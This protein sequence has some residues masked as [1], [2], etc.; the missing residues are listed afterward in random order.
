MTISADAKQLLERDR[1][2]VAGIE[3]LRFFPIAVQ[4]GKGSW[5]TE[6]GGRKLLDLSSTWTACGLGHG[7]P[8]L[9][10]AM[11]KAAQ[12]PAGAGGLSAAHPDSVG[13]AE[14]LLAFVP[15][16]GD[17][18][19]YFGHAGTDANEVVFRSARRATGRKRIVT[20]KHGYHGG[21]GVA[22]KVSDVHIAAGVEADPDLFL[23]TYPNPFRPHVTGPD[24][25]RASLEATIAEIDTELAKGDVCCLMAEPILSDGGLIVPPRGF[26]SRLLEVCRKH[27]VLLA[28]DE[29]KMGL[30]RP[31]VMHAFQLD[32]IVPDIVTFGKLIGGGLP[33]S[34]AVA[35]AWL[36]DGPPASALLTTAGNPICTAVGRQVMRTLKEEDIPARAKRAGDRFLA[37]LRALMADSDVIGDVRGE[38]LAIGLELVKSRDT[39]ARDRLLTTKVVYRAFEL[40]AV[41]HYVGGNVLEIT[42]PLVIEDSEIDLAVDIL[43]QSIKDA[44]AGKVS[45][46]TVA[47]FA[48]W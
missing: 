3:K 15:G 27:D 47:P 22:M 5:L 24:P 35:P 37:G 41:V 8:A 43:E 28:I 13:F 20:F 36:I 10:E 44:V 38:G 14:E 34:A 17:R 4:S 25:I 9:I 39:N 40:G 12:N 42:P 11:T 45:D 46:E 7:H 31:G 33:L 29:V 16:K 18:R 2:A 48:G 1:L 26:L 30:G 32:G 21:L 19:V 6:M 23:A